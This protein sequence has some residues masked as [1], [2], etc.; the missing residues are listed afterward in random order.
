MGS[1]PLT[2]AIVGG[3]TNDHLLNI[4]YDLCHEICGHTTRAVA[5]MMVYKLYS[6]NKKIKTF[7]YFCLDWKRQGFD[8]RDLHRSKMIVDFNV[9]RA[10]PQ[11]YTEL[12]ASNCM[13]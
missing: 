10:V 7:V 1:A 6:F 11:Q 9:V 8:K 13:F 3:H 5:K 4:I 2:A 12:F